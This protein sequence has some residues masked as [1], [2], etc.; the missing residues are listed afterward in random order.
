MQFPL[1][2]EL[3]SSQSLGLCNSLVLFTIDVHGSEACYYIHELQVA[4]RLSCTLAAAW[5]NSTH[6]DIPIHAVL[7]TQFVAG[8]HITDINRLYDDPSVW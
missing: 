5:Q 6:G 8:Q 7:S 3:K 4:L 1:L 2:V